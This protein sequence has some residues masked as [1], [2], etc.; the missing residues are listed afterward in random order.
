MSALSGIK[1]QCHDHLN[2]LASVITLA[3]KDKPQHWVIF[4]N[5]DAILRYNHSIN[6]A[7][8]VYQLSQ[9]IKAQYERKF[10]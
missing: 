9:H 2:R 1:T 10:T 8:A 3:S 6:Y 4:N 5:F 7:M